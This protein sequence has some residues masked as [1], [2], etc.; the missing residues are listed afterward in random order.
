MWTWEHD[1]LALLL[2][3]GSEAGRTGG[4]GQSVLQTDT[5]VVDAHFQRDTWA[6]GF[7]L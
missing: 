2:L 7:A 1:L 5:V 4:S 6:V 3:S